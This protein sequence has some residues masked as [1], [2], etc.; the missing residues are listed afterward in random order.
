[1]SKTQLERDI[2]KAK[3]ALETNKKLLPIADLIEY[4]RQAEAAIKKMESELPKKN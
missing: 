4:E 3:S 2:L 1:M